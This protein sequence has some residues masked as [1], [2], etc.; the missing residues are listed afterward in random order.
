MTTLLLFLGKNSDVKFIHNY[1]D[2]AGGAILSRNHSGISF[3]QNS[4]VTFISNSAGRYGAAIYSQES[5]QVIFTGNSK[6]EFNSNIDKN[7]NRQLLGIIYVER[8]VYIAFEDNATT[9]L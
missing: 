1:A 8:N 3:N 6:I 7:H 4:K 9:L 5:S 2:N